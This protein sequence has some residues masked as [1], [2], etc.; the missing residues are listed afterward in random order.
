MVEEFRMKI[1]RVFTAILVVGALSGS[2]SSVVFVPDARAQGGTAREA[3]N[4]LVVVVQARLDGAPVLGGGIIFG[5]NADRIYVLTANHLM[6]KGPTDAENVTVEIMALPGEQI[7]A[8]LLWNTDSALDVA[9]L[10]I[11]N[12]AAQG[13]PVGTIPLNTVRVTTS[14][15]TGDSVFLVGHPGAARWVQHVKPDVV[16]QVVGEQITFQSSFV[17]RGHSGGGLFTKDFALLGMIV[18]DG[19]PTGRAVGVSRIIQSLLSWNFPVALSY[20]S[21]REGRSAIP[22]AMK[23][24]DAGGTTSPSVNSCDPITVWD[25]SK[26]PPASRIERRCIP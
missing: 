1:R 10:M 14:V 5:M 9:V 4:R 26:Y 23:G 25:F 8:E 24:P 19:P 16:S 17:E 15:E 12:V 18:R 11:R 6:R 13:I 21:P 7:K 2:I 20:S 22:N 3:A